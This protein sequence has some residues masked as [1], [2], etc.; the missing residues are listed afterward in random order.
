MQLLEEVID[1]K[2]KAFFGPKILEYFKTEKEVSILNKL[3]KLMR[4]I[5]D[6]DN[7]EHILNC[8]FNKFKKQQNL[9]ILP[10]YF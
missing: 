4:I 3:V 2:S 10:D 8:L 9:V 1:Q 5:I 7:F 6:E